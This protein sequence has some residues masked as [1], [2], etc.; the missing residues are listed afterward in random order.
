[1]TDGLRVTVFG[2]GE[3]GC[4]IAA[5]LVAAGVEVHA[6][7]PRPVATP[8]GVARFEVP[9]TAVVGAKFICALTAA[10][11]AA[12]ALGQALTAIE[13]GTVYADFATSAAEAKQS[14]AT[15][16]ASVA[17][18]FVDVALMAPVP[19]KGLRTPTLVS[20]TGAEE[21]LAAFGALGM[22]VENAGNEAGAAATRKLLRSVVIKGLAGVLIE[23]MHAARAA[24]L[25]EETWQS[26]VGQFA[27][28][29][30][31]FLRRIVEG[32]GGHSLRRLHEMEAAAEL[33]EN[34]GVEPVMT[35]STVESLRRIEA[36]SPVP[37]LP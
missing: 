36:G 19:G 28:A 32:T 13:P 29:D 4:I 5:D 15:T 12:G 16:A 33:L 18:H 22:P 21:F 24:G 23:A 7:D 31:D 8:A 2:L 27:A 10:A 34:L 17:I 26:L 37:E 30:E 20:G 6:F 11:D 25:A 35:R 14:L 3:A 1:M 9:A